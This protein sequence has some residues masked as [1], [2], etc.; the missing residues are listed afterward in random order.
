MG[1][2]GERDQ[3]LLGLHAASSCRRYLATDELLQHLT[4]CEEN[5][6]HAFQARFSRLEIFFFVCF[7]AFT[8]EITQPVVCDAFLSSV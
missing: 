6:L 3:G 8:G 2:A 1:S 4:H 7:K 5:H